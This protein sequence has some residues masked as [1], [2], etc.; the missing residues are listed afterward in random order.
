MEKVYLKPR[1]VLQKLAR[2]H[3][4][5]TGVTREDIRELTGFET[6]AQKRNYY[7]A[8]EYFFKDGSE[9]EVEDDS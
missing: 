9:L 2:D 8:L 7:R 5:L 6:E 3:W 1:E 4:E